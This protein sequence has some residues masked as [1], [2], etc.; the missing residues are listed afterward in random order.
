MSLNTLRFTVLAAAAGTLALLFFAAR[1]DHSSAAALPR[2]PGGSPRPVVV[3]LFTSEGCSSC[4]PADTLL[5]SLSETQPFDGIQVLALEEHVDYWNHLGWADPF[6]SR[7]FSERQDAYA[8]H[9]GNGSAYTPQVV[10]DGSMEAVGSRQSSI[11]DIVQKAAGQPKAELA[12]TPG[13][14]ASGSQN[15]QIQVTGLGQVPHY[16]SAELW[17]AVTEKGLQSDVKAGENSG[18]TLRH[19]PVVRSLTKIATLRD[20]SDY[21]GQT[22]VALA[23]DWNRGNL[24]FVAFVTDKNS[25][26]VLAAGATLPH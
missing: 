19:A 24:A 14:P 7:Q 9:F 26:K 21:K 6:S 3:E 17:L 4:P 16:K 23:K 13:P 10:V 15:L 1:P 8:Y 5:R 12:I 20:A 11:R 22:D 18:S 2:S 25:H